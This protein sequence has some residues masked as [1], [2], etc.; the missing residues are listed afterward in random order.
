MHGGGVIVH[1]CYKIYHLTSR[2]RSTSILPPNSSMCF[3]IKVSLHP[4]QQFQKNNMAD[5]I[6]NYSISHTIYVIIYYNKKISNQCTP[7]IIQKSTIPHQVPLPFA[8]TLAAPYSFYRHTSNTRP[9]WT[10]RFLMCC[11]WCIS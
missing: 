5:C 11:Y 6:S 3:P 1:W 9:C 7:Q 10:L 2:T 8:L 4:I